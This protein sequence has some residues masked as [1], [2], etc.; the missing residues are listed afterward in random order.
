MD[1]SH[2]GVLLLLRVLWQV[3]DDLLALLDG[4]PQLLDIRSQ[5]QALLTWGRAVWGR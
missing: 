1:E 3:Q 5:E 2:H 4:L